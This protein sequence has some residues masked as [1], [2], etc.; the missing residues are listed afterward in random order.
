M[1][2]K[3]HYL[4]FS[5]LHLVFVILPGRAFQLYVLILKTFPYTSILV[6][7]CGISLTPGVLCELSV[8]KFHLLLP[9]TGVF[10]PACSFSW[11]I[12]T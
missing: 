5:T 8:L 10:A 11:S 3:L 12:Y 4:F 9:S 6:L 1:I 7:F 2:L